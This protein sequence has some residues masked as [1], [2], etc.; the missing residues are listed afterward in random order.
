MFLQVLL[1]FITYLIFAAFLGRVLG[2]LFRLPLPSART[3]NFSFGTRNSFVVLPF[4]VVIIIFQS[5]VELF[6]TAA[7]PRWVLGKLIPERSHLNA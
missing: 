7:Y 5:L 4:A 2:R 3:L 6:G 1:L